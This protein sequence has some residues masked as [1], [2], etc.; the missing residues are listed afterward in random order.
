MRFLRAIGE[1]TVL[2]RFHV[3]GDPAE[4]VHLYL[5]GATQDEKM[6]LIDASTFAFLLNATCKEA[7][8]LF[9]YSAEFQYAIMLRFVVG[10]ESGEPIDLDGKFVDSDGVGLEIFIVA[11]DE[12]ATVPG[13]S[14]L[15]EA[16]DA[17]DL[18]DH[19]ERMLYPEFAF[20]EQVDRA[21]GEPGV[22]RDDDD[23]SQQQTSECVLILLGTHV[24]YGIH[25]Y[26]GSFSMILSNF[27]QLLL[28]AGR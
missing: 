27:A 22:Q 11:G 14:V 9:G 2:F 1:Q 10:G 23:G 13:L 4:V 6:E 5:T 12:K 19:F 25:R 18:I 28:H 26:A 7:K 20:D 24:A 17:L 3:V 15:G 21:E 16:H 8:P